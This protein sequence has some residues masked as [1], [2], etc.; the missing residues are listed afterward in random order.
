MF[1]ISRPK[2]DWLSCVARPNGRHTL[3]GCV[4]LSA[5]CPG[6]SVSE[7]QP[8]GENLSRLCSSFSRSL[9]HET[10]LVAKVFR[11]RNQINPIDRV[12]PKS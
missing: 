5:L 7:A 12:S 4:P 9:G 2:R 10:R 6:L 11:S 3:L 8:S 1:L